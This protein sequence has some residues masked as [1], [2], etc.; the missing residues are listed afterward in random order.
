MAV[1]D[2]DR[3][4]AGEP[5]LDQPFR[6]R[7]ATALTLG[8]LS[9]SALLGGDPPVNL[10]E[11]LQGLLLDDAAGCPV[12]MDLERLSSKFECPQQGWSPLSSNQA[13][14]A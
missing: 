13:V 4:A 5:L 3:G 14:W 1:V 7:W 6:R 11:L 10:R 8:T 12:T 2:V 9:L